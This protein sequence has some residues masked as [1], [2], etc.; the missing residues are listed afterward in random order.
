MARRNGLETDTLG[1]KAVAELL[2]TASPELQTVL[3]L[4]QQLAK[5][6]VRKYQTMERA[7]CD[8]GRAHGCFAFTEPTAQAAGQ[9]DLFNYKIFRRIIWRIS[10]MPAHLSNPVTLMP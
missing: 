8:D 4:R 10:Q 5:S 2:K 1:K 9:A 7:A 3:T 6:S